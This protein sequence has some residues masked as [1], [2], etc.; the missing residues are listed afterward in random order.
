MT[1]HSDQKGARVATPLTG[2]KV[3]MIVV[4][5]F[6]VIIT[7]NMFMAYKAVSTFPGLEV[8]NSYVASQTFDADRAAQEALGW[9]VTQTYDG[10]DV[11]ILIQ[12]PG[13]APAQ[14]KE[15]S[16]LIGRKTESRNDIVADFRYE[17]GFFLAPAALDP[18]AWLMHLDVTAPDGTKFKQRINF[19]VEG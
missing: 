6:G 5:F 9:K 17:H 11:S 4:G 19:F 7:V 14:I 15:I 1:D 16:A 3:L 2:F 10:K 8:A 18:G 12:E 13:G